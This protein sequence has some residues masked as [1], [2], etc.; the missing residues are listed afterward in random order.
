MRADSR[1]MWR[2]LFLLVLAGTALSPAYSAVPGPQIGSHVTSGISRFVSLSERTGCQEGDVPPPSRQ[3]STERL[4]QLREVMRAAGVTGY[5]ILSADDHQSAFLPD[6]DKRRHFISGFTGSA[7]DAVVTLTSAA[8]WTDSRYYQEADEQLDCNWLLMKTGYSSTPSMQTWLASELANG[9]VV[10]ADP[11]IATNAQW[12]AWESILGASSINLTALEERLVDVIWTDQPDYPNDTLIVMNTTFTG[13]TWLS[14]L[15]NIRE[16]LRGRNADTIVITAL[17]EVAWTLNLRGADV[18]YTPVFRGYLIVGLNYATLY[19]PP[20][21]ITQDVRLHL[22]ADGANT[23]AVVRIKDYDTFWSDLQEINSLSTGVWLPSAYSYAS[24]V[25]RQIFQTIGQSI[26]QSL[27]SP[28]LLTKTMKNDIEAA[29]MRDA[30]IRDAVA[31]C[32]MLH[33]LDED[34]ESGREE[35]DEQRVISSLADLRRAQALNHG[36]SFPTIAGFGPNSALPHYES[37]NVTN[38]VLDTSSLF[39]LDSGGQ[40][41]DGTT[42]VTRTMHYGTPTNLEREIY[43]NL[44]MG[45]INLAST[46]FPEGQTLNTLEVLIRAPLYSMGLDYGHGSTH[47]V[48]TFLGVHEEEVNQHLRERRVENH[49]GKSPSSP[50]QDLNLN[51]QPRRRGRANEFG[52]RLENVVTVVRADV[53]I[54][55]D[56]NVTYLAFDPVTLVPYEQK[57]INVSMLSGRQ[58]QWLNDYHARTR[59]LVGAEMLRQNLTNTYNWL[60]R[61]TQPIY[62]VEGLNIGRGI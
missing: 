15:E 4:S 37:N 20:D 22:E 44:L 24:G 62:S 21:K 40:Y 10:A 59:E 48:G 35:W 9:D 58:L 51:V 45:C 27:A 39:M 3:N 60:V 23:S 7:G 31:L 61:K 32:Q 11:K 29:G 53:S 54:T 38:R 26:R 30:H 8:L 50:D 42:D 46:R 47:G 33:R 13:A 18:P 49:S 41:L 19:V 25:S 6:H 56:S 5:I 28:V 34:V 55:T 14:K 52:M 16:Q 1:D 43:T 17:D 2:L 57:L 36:L 12:A